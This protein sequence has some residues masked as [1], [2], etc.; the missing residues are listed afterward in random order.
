MHTAGLSAARWRA[1]ILAMAV[2]VATWAAWSAAAKAEGPGNGTAS[3]ASLGDSYISG[4]AGRWAGNTNEEQS[5][6][7]RSARR[8]TTTTKGTP[9]SRSPAATARCRRRSTSAAAST[10]STSRARARTYRDVH[11]RRGD[12]K[13]GSTST[14]RAANRG[15]AL[16]LEQYAR[17]TTSRWSWSR[18]ARNNF[19]FA[20][21]CRLRRGLAASPSWWQNY[22]DDDSNVTAV[23]HASNVADADGRDQGRDPERRQAMVEAGYTDELYAIVVQDYSSPIPT[24]SGFR[25]PEEGGNAG[26]IGGCGIWN[27]DANWAN[28]KRVADDRQ[29]GEQRRRAKRATRTSS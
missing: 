18:S 12:F 23:L 3:I 6:S 4:E 28:G 7:T 26:S 21:S 20:S 17:R 14:A 8:R 9:P 19:N 16:M 11:R 1:A 22:C 29:L 13:P 5:G 2:A 10:A 15:Q 27:T 25:Y 24:G